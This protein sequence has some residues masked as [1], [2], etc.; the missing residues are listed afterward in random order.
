MNTIKINLN[1]L[2]MYVPFGNSIRICI[3][4]FCFPRVTDIVKKLLFL[5]IFNLKILK[6]EI[7][8]GSNFS[9]TKFSSN[10]E[11]RIWYKK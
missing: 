4:L 5:P 6:I 10:V 7:G 11:D 1:Y 9:S 2:R 8:N 3:F